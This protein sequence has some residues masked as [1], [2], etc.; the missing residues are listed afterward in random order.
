VGSFEAIAA[1]LSLVFKGVFVVG[2]LE[3]ESKTILRMGYDEL[4]AIVIFT[5]RVIL[6]FVISD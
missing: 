3:H 4:A 2:L 6:L 1:L 5:A